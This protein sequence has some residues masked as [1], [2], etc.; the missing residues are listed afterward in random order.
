MTVKAGT[1]ISEIKK[2]LKKNNQALSFYTDNDDMSIGAVYANGAQDIS[3]EGE[4]EGTYI[5]SKKTKFPLI[6]LWKN[7]LL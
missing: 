2:Q 4:N 6:Q 5:I 3:L 1:P 7:I